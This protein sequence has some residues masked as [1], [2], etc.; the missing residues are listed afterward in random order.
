MCP[1]ALAI[2]RISREVPRHL[3]SISY[4]ARPRQAHP[5]R[6]QRMVEVARHVRILVERD[7]KGLPPKTREQLRTLAYWVIEPEPKRS[8]L[9]DI[10]RSF[11]ARTQ[12]AANVL[13][14][15]PD[16]VSSLLVETRRLIDAI[17][18]AVERDQESYERKKVY[19]LREALREWR[20]APSMSP[21][22]FREWLATS[23]DTG[24][25]QVQAGR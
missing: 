14:Y 9:Q 24:H 3:E 22:E 20:S 2:D 8:G 4:V 12:M 10:V 19:A 16:T 7:W 15:G 5:S 21:E 1:T 25:S 18:D 6:L 23:P 11:S 13:L 17:L